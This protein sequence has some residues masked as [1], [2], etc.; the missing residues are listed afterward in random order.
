MRRRGIGILE[1]AVVGSGQ[2][3]EV[4]KNLIG[5]SYRR[6]YR[7]IKEYSKNDMAK[8]KR[9]LK[10]RLMDELIIADHRISEEDLMK[11]REYCIKRRI[12]FLFVPSKLEVLTTN[13]IVRDIR[14]FPLMEVP[15]TRLEGWGYS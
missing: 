3:A 6:G 2:A 13:V 5:K 14:G 10:R 11:I 8:L 7:L 15:I 12:G 9:D 1:V 4:A